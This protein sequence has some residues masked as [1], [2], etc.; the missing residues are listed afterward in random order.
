[1]RVTSASTL[2]RRAACAALLAACQQAQAGPP[3]RTDDP[4]PADDGR[5]EIYLY[6]EG[7]RTRDG[8]AGALPGF[9]VNYGAAPDL[10]LAAA[11]SYGY[12]H[13][14]E[15][16]HSAYD[17]TEFGAKY[18]FAHE[19]DAGWR[20]QISFYP[21]VEIPGDGGPASTFLPLWAQKDIG[22]WEVFGG[23]GYRIN[24][25]H[26]RR[27]NWFAGI[28]TLRAVGHGLALGGELFRE[29]ADADDAAAGTG[30]NLALHQDLNALWHIVA[31]AG[32]GLDAVNAD[33]QF[34]YYLGLE[35]TI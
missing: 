29:T 32:R 1:M 30:F 10:Q 23:G 31:A 18:R 11:F 8:T 24:P 26:G 17:A 3:F 25:G 27:N 7:T 4:E 34:S 12:A 2:A 14:D 33:N 16:W 5:Y 21:S 35:L 20:P 19:E 9:E 28:G 15:G 6:S 22:G 13:D